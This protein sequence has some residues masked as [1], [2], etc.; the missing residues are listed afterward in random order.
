MFKKLQ[1]WI[2][3]SQ[4]ELPE[5]G[6]VNLTSQE[7]SCA[8]LDPFILV[9]CT[10]DIQTYQNLLPAGSIVQWQVNHLSRMVKLCT[11][12]YNTLQICQHLCIK[13]K[14]WSDYFKGLNQN[15]NVF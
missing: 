1:D 13:D 11:S 3:N 9:S 12:L 4:N 15:V 5:V 6:A 7:E 2:K 8:C 14:K 10:W